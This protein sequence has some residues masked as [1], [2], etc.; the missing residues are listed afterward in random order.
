M[1]KRPPTRELAR[2]VFLRALGAVFVIAFVS[3]GV[4]VDGLIGPEGILPSGPYLSSIASASARSPLTGYAWIDQLWRA[5]TLAWWLP[6]AWAGPIL[7]WTGALAALGVV[8][9]R[10]QG[11]LL[12]FCYATYASL[13]T[14]GQTFLGF[15]W[16]TLLCEVGL[17]AS[18]VAPW[19]A[20]PVAA[21]DE[22]WWLL[23]WILFR[24]M[25][26]AGVVKLTSGDVSWWDGTALGYHYET[27][28]LP[29]PLSWYADALPMAW[30][31]VET[32]IT[33]VIE[34]LIAPLILGPRR[35]RALA[36]GATAGLMSLLFFTGNYGFF[37]LLTIA[38]SFV[39]LDDDH[40]RRVAP[41]VKPPKRP[42]ATPAVT[43][44]VR[45]AAG[46]LFLGSLT[47]IPARYLHQAVPEPL[48]TMR[49]VLARTRAVNHYGLFARMTRT[50][51]LPALEARWGD[52]AWTELTWRW[53]TSDPLARPG[54]VAPHMPRLDWQLW[55]A[56]L[57]SCEKNPWADSLLHRLVQG[58]AP[59]TGLVGDMRLQGRAPDEVRLVLYEWRFV[60][61]G[62]PEAASGAWWT[63]ELK[64]VYCPAV[65]RSVLAM[66][67]P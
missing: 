24:L 46:T 19:R 66:P 34:L 33:F 58:S 43:W 52:G 54:V 16:D 6:D 12:V 67:T 14:I 15:Q 11:P 13:G 28:P 47:G 17:A 25:F 61:P 48:E 41:G 4:Q 40:W 55:F 32:L 59:V 7:C 9:G 49:Q 57:G 39:L 29:N 51:P 35:F 21:P 5:P 56:G 22:A 3:L 26:F 36:F 64:G 8:A 60:E 31:R 2:Q 23:R 63:R 50:R 20:V 44:A 18:L 42:V 38:L 45:V 37:Q 27:Q 10:R 30:H 1:A 65:R 53:Q 62:S